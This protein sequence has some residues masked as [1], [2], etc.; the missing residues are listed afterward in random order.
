MEGKGGERSRLNSQRKREGGR[1]RVVEKET[2]RERE[3][4]GG[5]EGKR[6]REE[7]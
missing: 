7:D 1:E 4:K 3:R 2:D 6:V 5:G